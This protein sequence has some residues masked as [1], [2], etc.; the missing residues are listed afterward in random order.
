MKGSKVDKAFDAFHNLLVNKHRLVE[1]GAALNHAVADG[2]YF[3]HILD[4][5]TSARHKVFLIVECG[6]VVVQAAA[7][8]FHTL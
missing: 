5:G 4:N 2:R 6:D 8:G 1:Q 7:F 3:A